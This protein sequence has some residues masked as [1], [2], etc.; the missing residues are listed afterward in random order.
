[1]KD[2]CNS[3]ELG[4]EPIKLKRPTANSEITLALRVLEGCCLLCK[5]SADSAYRYNAVKAC[6]YAAIFI[7]I[8][9]FQFLFSGFDNK[10]V[11]CRCY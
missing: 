7:Y 5:D 3:C 9:L 1:M 10:S 2:D 8:L 4:A 11:Q 6:N